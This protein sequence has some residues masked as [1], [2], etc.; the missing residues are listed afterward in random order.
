MD[1]LREAAPAAATLLEQI[2]DPVWDGRMNAFVEAWDHAQA[3]EWLHVLANP[4]SESELRA[5]LDATRKRIGITVGRL[6]AELAWRHCLTQLTPFQGQ[7]LRAWEL[8]VKKIG[9]GTGKYANQRRRE[10]RKHL[11]DCRPAIP[12]WVMPIYRVAE[13]IEMRPDIFDVVIVDEA[14]QSGLEALFLQY[15]ARCLIVVGDE[16]QISPENIG[17]NREEVSQLRHNLIDDLPFSGVYTVDN[18]FFDQAYIRYG[19]PIR[20]REHFRCMPEIIQFSNNLCYSDAPLVPL[21][22]CGAGRITPAVKTTFV[23]GGYQK[24]V[25]PRITNPVEAQA[26]VQAIAECCG[27]SEYEGKTMGVISLLGRDQARVIQAELIGK[28]SAAEIEK[29]MLICGDAYAFQGDERDVIFLSMVSALGDHQIGVLTSDSAKKRFNVAA[30]RAKEQMWLFHSIPLE[31]LNPKCY[32]HRLLQYCLHPRVGPSPVGESD[33]ESLQRAAQ[34]QTRFRE[35]P[36]QPFESWFEVD[37]FLKVCERG[38]RVI[39]QFRIGSYRVDMVVEGMSGRLAV[40]CD[41]DEW[42]GAERYGEDMLRQRQ[43]ERAG[44][45]FWRIRGSVFYVDPDSAMQGLWTT[46][47]SLRIY[48]DAGSYGQAQPK[49]VELPTPPEAGQ[50]AFPLPTE[51]PPSGVADDG[52][53]ST[54]AALHVTTARQVDSKPPEVA[55]SAVTEPNPPPIQPPTVFLPSPVLQEI[56]RH[57]QPYVNWQASEL[58]SPSEDNVRFVEE[59][60][61]EIVASE[62]PILCARAYRIYATAVGVHRIGRQIRHVF[63]RAVGHAVREGILEQSNEMGL[64]GQMNAVVR[65]YGTPRIVPRERGDRVLEEIP[66]SEI[67]TVMLALEKSNLGPQHNE[68]TLFRLT[69]QVY[70]LIR[71]TESARTHL[72]RARATPT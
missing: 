37:V 54:P 44:Y 42:H 32:R 22:Q 2:D 34:S 5:K 19:T 1:R 59:G 67:A 58:L 52:P 56:R 23:P 13:T 45:P 72:K 17:L 9:K 28:I 62:G 25:S 55:I 51:V 61:C 16:Q 39:P 10:A 8:V 49:G 21:K 15:I 12:A 6:S 57:L 24:G 46:L 14:S 40:E 26:I 43:L 7:S 38:Y 65:T 4:S 53:G 71:L 64:A 3:H 27:S 68:E 35:D 69:L 41:G 50:S 33:I 60:L 70:G 48:R 66:P 30:S 36:P 31:E 18:S 20:L 63:N 47:E 11:E 29:R